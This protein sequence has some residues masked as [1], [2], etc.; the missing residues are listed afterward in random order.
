MVK[1]LFSLTVALCL[2]TIGAWAGDV[3]IVDKQTLWTFGDYA[4][5]STAVHNY[6]GSGLFLHSSLTGSGYTDFSVDVAHIAHQEGTFSGTDVAWSATSVLAASH[7][8]GSTLAT[9]GN[10]AAE[11]ADGPDATLAFN[12]NHSGKL[13]VVYGATTE[14]DGT[15]CIRHRNSGGTVFST[16]YEK[17][18]EG[19]R[20]TGPLAIPRRAADYAFT[21]EEA[22][23][24]LDD[25]GTVYLGG[26]QPYCIYAILFVPNT[27]AYFDFEQIYKDNNNYELTF[28]DEQL[29][30]YYYKRIDSE[31]GQDSNGNFYAVTSE[32]VNS[33]ISWR[34]KNVQIGATGLKPTKGDR[35]FAIHG[36]KA[37]DVIRVEFSG[38]IYYARHTT[39]GTA[40]KGIT[41]GSFITSGE[42]Y[43]VSQR[44]ET[45]DYVVLYP[46]QATTISKISINQELP[47][48][49]ETATVF[50][51]SPNGD[52]GNRG[53]LKSSPFKTLKK[54]QERV[55]EG[56]I[57]HILP[58]TYQ[59]TAAE[60]MDKTSSGAWNIVYN[61]NK[62]GV[63]YI[64]EVDAEGH[65]PVFDFS[66]LA[67]QDNKRITGFYLTAQDIV[68]RNIE[69]IGIKVPTTESNTQSENFRLNGAVNCKLQHIAAHHGQGI[70]FYL[71]GNSKGNVIEN[72]DA[73]EN[74]DVTNRYNSSTGRYAGENND[75][76]GCHVNAGN[77]GNRFVRCRAWHNADDGFDFIKCYSVATAEECVAYMNGWATYPDGNLKRSG[78][79][80]GIKAGGYGKGAI[81]LPAE[82][83]PMHVV[84]NSIAAMNA[85]GGFYANHHLGGLQFEGNRAYQNGTDYRLT[86]RSLESA[87]TAIGSSDDDS[88]DSSD[89]MNQPGYGPI[90]MSNLSFG[91]AIDKVIADIDPA[92]CT[93]AG[94]SFSY[95]NGQWSNAPYKDSDF[96]STNTSVLTKERDAEGNLPDEV[97][98]FLKLN[99]AIEPVDVPAVT[100]QSETLGQ[101]TYAVSYP[102]D[103]ELHY[104]LPGD[105]K[106]TVTTDG[107]V[108]EGK[109]T[110]VLTVTVSG[111]MKLYAQKG[112]SVSNIVVIN[113]VVPQPTPATTLNFIQLYKKNKNFDLAISDTKQV[114]YLAQK[115][116]SIGMIDRGWNFYALTAAPISSQ[117][118]WREKQ[119]ELT[120]D[121][122]K[123]Q[124]EARPFAIHGL[125]EGDVIRIEF[126]GDIYYARHSEKGDVLEGL[127]AGDAIE[128]A[129]A[130]TVGSVDVANSYVVFFPTKATTI[131]QIS[132]NE[133][134][135][136][137]SATKPTIGEPV[138]NGDNSQ[139]FTITFKKGETLH[140]T[141]PDSN[142]EQSVPYSEENQGVVSV[143]VFTSGMLTAWTTLG[144]DTEMSDVASVTVLITKPHSTTPVVVHMLGDSTM[145]HYDQ[146][147]VEEAGMEGWGDYLQDCLTSYAT[148]HNW[149]DKGESARSFYNKFWLPEVKAKVQAGDYVI[150]QFGHNDQKSV[151]T[152]VYDDYLG[153]LV[154]EVKEIGATPIIATSICR[155]LFD[156]NGKV[157]RL[158][159][160]DD[161]DSHGVSEDDH[162][163]DFP[164]HAIK[165]AEDKGIQWIDLTAATKQL[166]EDFGPSK[167][168]AFFP[169]GGSTHTNKLGAQTVAKLAA[170]LMYV[171]DVLAGYV[172]T[173]KLTL[174]TP[175][176][177]EEGEDGGDDDTSE[178][179]WNFYMVKTSASGYATF[180][181]LAEENLKVPEGLTVYAVTGINDGGEVVLAEMGDV[182]PDG[183]GV[184]VKGTANMEY[185]LTATTDVSAYNGENL[186]VKNASQQLLPATDGDKTNYL[187]SATKFVKSTGSQTIR[188]KQA[189]LSVVSTLDE[190]LIP[191]ATEEPDTP[192]Y[193]IEN[194]KVTLIDDSR[195]DRKVY[196]VLFGMNQKLYY[197]RPGQDTEPRSQ[198][199]KT[200]FITNP[201]TI[202]VSNNGAFVYWTQETID[203]K[204]Y[205]S[206]HATVMVN[207]I[208]KRPSVALSSVKDG[209]SEYVVTFSEGTTLYYEIG[210]AEEQ[211][212]GEGSTAV[213]EVEK[214]GQLT[215]YSKNDYVESDLLTTTVYAPT[216]APLT[217]GY[218]DFAEITADQGIDVPVTLDMTQPLSIEG[219]TLYRPSELTAA[220]FEGRYAFGELTRN[221]QIRIRTNRQLY[222]AAGQD[223]KMAILDAQAGDIV[224]VE[225][226][227]TILINDPTVLTPVTETADA[228]VAGQLQSGVS[229]VVEQDGDLLLTLSTSETVVSITKMY[230]GT[231][232]VLKPTITDRG[233]NVVR[234]TAGKS[235]TGE[236]VTTCYTID[237]STP[238]PA[239]GTSGPYDSFDVELLSGG[240]VTFKAVSY[241]ADGTCSDVASL[242]VLI[243]DRVHGE[244]FTY[245]DLVDENGNS[246]RAMEVYNVQGQR[247]SSIRR[248]KLYILDG[249]KVMFIKQ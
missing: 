23:V 98:D 238:S 190:I 112:S 36:L 249:K 210:D 95:Q 124:N 201:L 34:E 77:P 226:T 107:E 92:Q 158:G 35:P 67:V 93:I 156:K 54:A 213:I 198:S 219:E 111:E 141:T 51:V 70:G 237:G 6:G 99:E 159:R 189:Y 101:V 127:I 16:V 185:N 160:I 184:L 162:S 220:T 165:V 108:A 233:K 209:Y 148:V 63:Q 223:L 188:T 131:S 42:A 53:T 118:S 113:V 14:N 229:Y 74:I 199:F 13:Y 172:D 72:C 22:V 116:A 194:A 1:R 38:E 144:D 224:Y 130:Y 152:D 7:G 216:K 135:A 228:T 132:F 9:L 248:G 96:A 48:D 240:Y 206:E 191:D 136:P 3:T 232:L 44:D 234:I 137:S 110:V 215:A 170:R 163:Y 178:E 241:T 217:A 75:G 90:L 157:T 65:R 33:L 57:I 103:A 168:T 40:L 83:A 32:P 117:I 86:N 214:S 50:Y 126:K 225:Y 106:E 193:T 76:F 245:D 58:G 134:L 177:V 25:G 30:V 69:T 61:L 104:V 109:K 145:S 176:D 138:V 31:S 218:L 203:G 12:H 120:A 27:V 71:T 122:L 205:E 243:E 79:G 187:F 100:L 149:A 78:N 211:T 174:P 242:L 49:D 222:F 143:I 17:K 180:S 20:Y 114:L 105:N 2:A 46:T 236:A 15:F 21:I 84:S 62:N 221:N 8:A 133:E 123:P 204:N 231:P 147:V 82:G 60:Y 227:G 4:G 73:Y 115:D 89:A 151:T 10:V 80:N 52:D 146:S 64:G 97:F 125:K 202:T 207:S 230:V 173:E 87:G 19:T 183:V 37:D 212:V 154:D 246:A 139:T 102:A 39:R 164:Y 208:A 129:K 197:M 55:P 119:V 175:D 18:M 150:V 167:A 153:K 186:L 239:N 24:S 195:K 41:S 247:V 56:G 235:L 11:S 196:Q 28:G 200:D 155:K 192:E 66:T 166:Y 140:Y 182:I 68:I 81:T 94:N 142:D 47:V 169:S 171:K 29:K 88:E 121:G 91:S 128:S 45:Y 244:S 26:S 59:V 161:G 85:A 5:Q 179:D 43:T 181:N